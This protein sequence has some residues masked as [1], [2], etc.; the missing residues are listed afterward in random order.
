[1]YS[2]SA[3]RIYFFYS[4]ADFLVWTQSMYYSIN[5]WIQQTVYFFIQGCVMSMKIQRTI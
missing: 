2:Q 4:I 1:M 5:K 3:A